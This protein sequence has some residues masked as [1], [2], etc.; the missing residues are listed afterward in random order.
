MDNY[1]LKNLT[2]L[3]T[4][5]SKGIGKATALKLASLGCNIAII[6]RGK[7]DIVSTVQEIKSI[8][9]VSCIGLQGDVT[10]WN[11][12]KE[13][14]SRIVEEFGKIDIVINSAG[15]NIPKGIVDTS[16]DEWNTVISVNLTGTFISCKLAA[17]Y[18]ISQK[19]GVI[20]NI[21][22]V[23]ARTGGRS[24]QYS[25]SKAGIEGLTKSLARQLAD[26][27]IRVLTISP[28]GTETDMAKSSWSTQ[29]RERLI[30]QTLMKRIA[31]PSEIANVIAFAASSNASFMTGTTIQVNGGYHLD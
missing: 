10:N 9:N 21:S 25:A 20:I 29:T 2:A 1:E 24:V 28:G 11:D 8:Y 5:G 30:D 6:A 27:Q 31:N 19:S 23:Q 13:C 7:K 15:V 14:Y 18:M 22:S 3:I 26:K 16:L 4:G 12:M 17:E